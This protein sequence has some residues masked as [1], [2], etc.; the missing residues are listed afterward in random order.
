MQEKGVFEVLEA[1]KLLEKEG[2]N[3]KAKI[4][5]NID[6]R[7]K[8]SIHKYFDSLKNLEYCGVVSGQEKKELLLWGT[9][10]ILP[11]YYAMEGQPI[12]ILEAMATGNLILTTKHAGIPDIFEDGVNGYFVEKQNIKSIV[13]KI[14]FATFDKFNSDAMRLQNYSIAKR[15]YTVENFIKN[16]ER[17][18]R[19]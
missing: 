13:A 15:E 18:F 17:I 11:T 10:F 1:L 4:A 5:G 8:D 16:I 12:S 14:K 9:I 7:H 19:N 6:E 2:F 3:F